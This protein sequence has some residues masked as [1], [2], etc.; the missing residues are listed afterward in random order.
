VR[1]FIEG[2]PE[3]GSDA[4]WMPAGTEGAP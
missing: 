2:R 3:T 1:Q 4:S